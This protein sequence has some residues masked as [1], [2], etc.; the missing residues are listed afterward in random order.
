MEKIAINDKH[1]YRFIVVYVLRE[2]ANQYSWNLLLFTY[3]RQWYPWGIQTLAVASNL[4][5]HAPDASRIWSLARSLKWSATY[6]AIFC[7]RG[8][9]SLPHTVSLLHTPFDRQT[10]GCICRITLNVDWG[11]KLYVKYIYFDCFSWQK[12]KLPLGNEPS[13]SVW[14]VSMMES[15]LTSVWGCWHA[16]S[17]LGVDMVSDIPLKGL[18]DLSLPSA[19]VSH[20]LL[21]QIVP[22]EQPVTIVAQRHRATSYSCAKIFPLIY[23][24]F[25]QTR[26]S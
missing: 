6:W 9:W 15:S 10:L 23:C 12:K 17:L 3:K 16:A 18:D 19:L 22:Y 1:C 21:V 24:V 8:A 14:T 25:T 11:I 7:F 20:Q 26:L 4:D 13:R 2:S 5:P